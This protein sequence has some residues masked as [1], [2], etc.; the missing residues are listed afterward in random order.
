MSSAG[1]YDQETLIRALLRG[2]GL[3]QPP[4]RIELEQTHLSWIL[5]AGEYVYKIKK[6]VRLDFVDFSTLERRRAACDDEFK[7]NRRFAPQLYVDV[8]AIGGA[9]NAP[10]IG[11]GDHVFEYAVRLR[12]FDQNEQL[13]ALVERNAVSDEELARFGTQLAHTHDASST[14]E[15]GNSAQGTFDTVLRNVREFQ[16]LSNSFDTEVAALAS[17][18]MQQW[19]RIAET[20]N[21]RCAGGKVRDCHGDLHAGNVVRLQ[22][23]LVAFDCI[24]FSAELRCIDVMSDVGFLVMDLGARKADGLAYA[25]LNG[26]LEESGDYDGARLLRFFAVYRALVRA[27]IA[28]LQHNSALARTYVDAAQRFSQPRRPMLLITCGLSG[29]GKTWLSSRLLAELQ[30]I[31]VR[32]DVERKRM[33][34]P[35]AHESSGPMTDQNIYSLQFNE[36]VYGLLQAHARTLIEAGESVVIDAAFL[37]RHERLAFVDLAREL[38]VPMRIV[39]CTAPTDVLERRLHERQRRGTDASEAD[40]AVMNRQIG[41]WEPFT[42]SERLTIEVATADEDSVAR[43][44][45]ALRALQ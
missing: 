10:I 31:R 1:Q 15:T 13:S 7:L 11:A 33:A 42:E 25:F 19:S 34:G 18:S 21:R 2:D 45:N 40:V 22:G 6:A 30:L 16:R 12:R 27:K 20:A 3:A 36:R 9:P 26:W 28:A 14:C 37:K 41:S 4:S 38:Q 44:M 35:R 43:C 8:V 5:L 39:H 29:S 24:E 23:Q 32:S 17:W